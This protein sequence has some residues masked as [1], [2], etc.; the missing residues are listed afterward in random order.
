MDETPKDQGNIAEKVVG[1]IS[2]DFTVVGKHRIHGWYAW[3]IVGIVF[4]MALGIVYVA[5]QNG[6]FSDS[7]A[8]VRKAQQVAPVGS[9]LAATGDS[10][11]RLAELIREK[12]TQPTNVK[13]EKSFV[14]EVN[15][16][17]FLQFS[18]IAT[19]LVAGTASQAKVVGRLTTLIN[20]LRVPLELTFT[21]KTGIEERILIYTT[22]MSSVYQPYTTD[23]VA[24]QKK[25]VCNCTF[26]ATFKYVIKCSAKGEDDTYIKIESG[27]AE[28]SGSPSFDEVDSA[29][30]ATQ[31]EATTAEGKQEKT[32]NTAD[33]CSCGTPSVDAAVVK[34]ASKST[35]KSC[36]AV[37]V[38]NSDSAGSVICQVSTD[39]GA[40]Q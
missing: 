2:K 36:T 6:E 1:D 19:M 16:E 15:G 29:G 25:G 18:P 8:A 4:G 5:N 21:T 20:N 10:Y 37:K 12:T 33:E 9:R 31:L 38:A 35:G 27:D 28:Y 26:A 39:V 32:C 17:K 13:I 11:P 22:A 7:E 24:D 14:N 34:Q 23:V 30:E 40:A 3:A